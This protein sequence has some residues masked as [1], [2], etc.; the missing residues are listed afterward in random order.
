MQAS[1]IVIRIWESF[2]LAISI[3][4]AILACL[5]FT[6]IAVWANEETKNPATELGL[7]PLTDMA[8]GDKYKGEDGGLYGG[9]GTSRPKS[10][11]RQRCGVS[12]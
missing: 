1:T 9:G 7:K 5:L 3:M 11:C 4:L 8:A 2:I 12:S 6:P 10:I